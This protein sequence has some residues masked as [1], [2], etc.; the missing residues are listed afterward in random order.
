MKT[1]WLSLWL[2]S[3]VVIHEPIDEPDCATISAFAREAATAGAWLTRD[4][5]IVV[6]LAC[7]E[8]D[9]VLALP[10]ASGDCEVG[11]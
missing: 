3:G 1:L 11:S 6:R 8:A 7:D 9:V 10:P 5:E 4:D 2:S